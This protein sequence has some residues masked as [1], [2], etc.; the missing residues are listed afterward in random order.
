MWEAAGD[1]LRGKRTRWASDCWLKLTHHL[2]HTQGH[3]IMS[4]S[5]L[6][7][8][9]ASR[10]IKKR[11]FNNVNLNSAPFDNRVRTLPLQMLKNG[12]EKSWE[13]K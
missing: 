8:P 9:E 2:T 5:E 10:K 3:L 4:Q 7:Y 11:L 6:Q 1:G 12:L 13:N